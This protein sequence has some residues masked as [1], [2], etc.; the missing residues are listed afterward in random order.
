LSYRITMTDQELKDLIGS[1]GTSFGAS[2]RETDRLIAEERLKTERLIAET[3]R[4]IAEERREAERV[5]EEERLKT[6]SIIAE[7]RREAERVRE[8]ERREAERVREEE[9]REAERVRE[10]ERREAER[11]RE[12]E[13]LKTERL[14][15]ETNRLIAEERREAERVREEERR[16]TNEEINEIRRQ[17]E[18]ARRKADEHINDIRAQTEEARRK[19]DEHINDIRAQ[20]EEIRRQADAARLKT[21]QVLRDLGIQIGGLGNKF[22]SFT[23][24]LA[25]PSVQRLLAERFGVEEFWKVRRR[26]LGGESIELDGLGVV[27]GSRNEA[28]IVEVKSNLRSDAIKQM[29]GILE[30]FRR[31]FPEYSAM[32]LYGV[33]ATADA[34]TETLQEAQKA[35]FYTITFENDLMQFRNASDFMPTSY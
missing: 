30:K 15:A 32:K 13:R 10:E 27:N 9:R 20:A 7:Q 24:G 23:E 19:A 28:Y 1:L 16:K 6:D 33:L 14:I 8:E 21:E 5:R 12:E 2:L 11:V 22:G 17:T 31:M 4:L 35:G 29:V 26:R 3:N 25:L 34:S 18:E